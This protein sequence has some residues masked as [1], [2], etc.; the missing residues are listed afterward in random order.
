MT[1]PEHAEF[2][3]LAAGYVLYALEPAD[4]QRLRRHAAHCPRC[5][6]AMARFAE[7]A[8]ALADTAPPAEP[9]PQ[10]GLRILAVTQ[11]GPAAGRPG[12]ERTASAAPRPGSAPSEVAPPRPRRRRWQTR[13]VAVAAAA[14][15]IAAGGTW[16]G[17]AASSSGPPSPLAACAKPHACPQVPLIAAAT[18]REAARVIVLGREVWMQSV[19]MASAPADHIYVL[20]QITGP[21]TP[22]AV[23]AFNV[24][25]GAHG[26][27]RIGDLAAPY[28][29]TAGFA[30]SVQRGHTIPATPTDVIASG[31][32]T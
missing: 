32:V 27:L 6:A 28:P 2:E 17:L 9:S 8:A 7:V 1:G 31:R 3:E 4:E 22:R 30:I 14:A 11:A 25:A 21:R 23:G 16:A 10:L 12:G 24:S 20:W 26:P 5:Q 19:D 18:H 15:L 29:G 13:W